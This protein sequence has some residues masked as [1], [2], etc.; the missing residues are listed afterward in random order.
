MHSIGHLLAAQG[1]CCVCMYFVAAGAF[2]AVRATNLDKFLRE[3]LELRMRRLID[4]DVTA[5]A[6]CARKKV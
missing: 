2:G 6:D 1:D 3:L 4:G 5:G